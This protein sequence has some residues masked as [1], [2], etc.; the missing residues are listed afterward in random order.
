MDNPTGKSLSSVISFEQSYMLKGIAMLMI[1]FI[2]SINEYECYY[3][4]WSE[5]LLVPDYGELGCS[6][7]FFLSGYGMLNSSVNSQK[8]DWNYLFRHILKLVIPFLAGFFLTAVVL[9]I[10]GGISAHDFVRILWLS[11][12]DGVDLWFFK[13]VI[14]NYTVMVMIFMTGYAV[15]K[16]LAILSLVYLVAI[17]AMYLL[18]CP[19]FWYVSI[20]QFPLGAWFAYLN[21]TNRMKK[22]VLIAAVTVF[23]SCYVM[24]NVHN[25]V[26]V[27]ILENTSF[28]IVTVV[29]FCHYVHRN[30]SFLMYIG[31]NSLYFYLLGIPVMEAIDSSHMPCFCYFIS[32]LLF[33]FLL[34]ILYNYVGR[35]HSQRP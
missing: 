5:C 14:I 26:P 24:K 8:A 30:S 9:Y 6:M 19:G 23:V 2:H 32:N 17:I 20:L 18:R 12:P 3:S 33:S 25:M 35:A 34:V 7:F 22:T 1:I 13:T 11:M 21:I 31:K 27:S 28:T 29:L 16:K 15:R 4:T 10:K